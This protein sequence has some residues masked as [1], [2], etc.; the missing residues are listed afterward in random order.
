MTWERRQV[1]EELSR[2]LLGAHADVRARAA[3][4]GCSLREAAWRVAVLRVAE[5]ETLRGIA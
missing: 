1:D 4:D 2:R 5:A 3:A